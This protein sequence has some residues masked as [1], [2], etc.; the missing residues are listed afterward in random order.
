MIVHADGFFTMQFVE[1][2]KVSNIAMADKNDT[3][4]DILHDI[5]ALLVRWALCL[6]GFLSSLLCLLLA[7]CERL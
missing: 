5:F 4:G 3:N 1:E 7:T 6:V 2:D